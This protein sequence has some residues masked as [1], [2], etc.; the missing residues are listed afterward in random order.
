M[1]T[2]LTRRSMEGSITIGFDAKRIV[3][4]GTGLG[5]YGR[6]LVSDLSEVDGL[7]LRLYAPDPGLDDLRSQVPE[8]ERVSFC[9]PEGWQPM[10]KSYWRTRAIT[11]QLQHDGVQVFHGLSGELPMGLRDAGIRSVVTIHDLIFM[12]H[13]EWYNAADVKIY[14]SKFRHA[15]AEA[16]RIVAISECTRRD[17]CELGDVDPE[18]VD[19]VYQSCATRFASMPTGEAPDDMTMKMIW[20]VREHYGLPDR[21]ILC[22]GTIEERK[23]AL[24]AL[25]ALHHLPDDLSLLLVGRSTDYT[26][27]V[28]RYAWDNGLGNRLR[29]LH[30]VP[31]KHLPA[32]YRLAEAF[33]YPSR[34]E[35]FGIPVIEAIRMGLPVVA[36]TGSCLEEAGGPHS[37]YVDPDDDRAMA[38]AVGQVLC[39]SPERQQRVEQS[40]QYIRRFENSD[41]AQRFA[42]IYREL[43]SINS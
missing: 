42:T 4:N 8:G 24:L 1:D 27:E 30:G 10:G 22:V 41:A 2:E 34:Y 15:I 12:H 39:G 3:R 7:M 32:I 37:L 18:R 43:S 25:K 33:V 9:Y 14:T 26:G 23:N 19:V 11:R 21:Y 20:Y 6:T 5:S 16:D 29:V 35:G 31:D 28:W 36:C 17:I 38:A 13:P 40:Q